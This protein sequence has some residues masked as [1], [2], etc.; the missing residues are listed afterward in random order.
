M[1]L[2]LTGVFFAYLAVF[3]AVIFCAWLFFGWQ[4]RRSERSGSPVL[5]CACCGRPLRAEQ[6]AQRLRCPDCGAASD[7]LFPP[8]AKAAQPPPP[9]P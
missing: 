6:P 2:T 9:S 8:A 4:R 3:L 5:T 7:S 1:S